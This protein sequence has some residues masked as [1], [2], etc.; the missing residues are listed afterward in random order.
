MIAVAAHQVFELAEALGVRRHHARLVEHQHAQ[1]V[2]G[3]QQFRAWAGCARCGRRCSPSPAV[4]GRGNTEPR[5]AARRPRPAWSWWLQVPLSLTDLPFRRKPFSRVEAQ[6]AD[7]EGGLVAVRD[8][9]A[10]FDFGDQLVQ[11]ALLRATTAPAASPISAVRRCGHPTRRLALAPWRPCR[12]SCPRDREWW[13][14]RARSGAPL[15]SLSTSVRIGTRGLAG[16]HLGAHQGAPLVDVH[17]LRL[18]Q[19]DVAIDARAFVEPAVA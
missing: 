19:P 14:S 13:K 5:R 16:A 2:A 9:A 10:G 18:D 3:V 4:C 11:I 12:P 17:R 1:L 6:R 7:A 8:G 15:P